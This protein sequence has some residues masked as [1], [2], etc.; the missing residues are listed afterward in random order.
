[1]QNAGFPHEQGSIG[2]PQSRYNGHM[3]V[4]CAPD[5]FKGS[6]SAA[7]AAAAMAAGVE[8]GA[9]GTRV[10]LLP[11]ADGGEGTVAALVDARNGQVE[12]VDVRDP[13][14]RPI[15]ADI[16]LLGDGVVVAE[17][18]LASGL[19]LLRLDE[20]DP[21]R[22]TTFGTGQLIRAAL[23]RGASEII[24]GVGGSAT[25][26]GGAGAL[27]ALGARLLDAE[28][29]QI[30]QGNAGLA[31]LASID[32]SDLDPRLRSTRIR[33]ACDVRNPL[34]GPNGAAAVFGPQK[35][36]RP[37]DIPILEAN[38]AHFAEIL[39]RDLGLRVVGVPGMGAA[40]GLTAGLLTIGGRAESGIELILETLHFDRQ[41]AVA[42]LVLTAEGRIDRQSA[43]GKVISG[44]LAH[45]GRVGVPVV[46]L[47]G[48]VRAGELNGLYAAGLAAAFPIADGPLT[49]AKAIART[50]SL[51]LQATERVIRLW[52]AARCPDPTAGG[53]KE[54]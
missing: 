48:S 31:D 24:L 34:T 13:L 8:R 29:R 39:A 50:E 3:L 19:P 40:G 51:L 9:P 11:L 2:A 32:L 4:I 1:V 21:F 49:Y 20:R 43:Q 18:A 47:G 45:A 15:R 30:R 53:K 52:L 28:G 14:D 27:Q 10:T 22:A 46:A 7:K 35:G 6:L 37:A 44:V 41:V 5:S 16:G 17:M 42:D 12:R 38:L 36:A 54:Q 25:V 23:D 33:V 26:D